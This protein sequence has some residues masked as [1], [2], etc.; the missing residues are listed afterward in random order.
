MQ[1]EML[2]KSA[3]IV[4][5]IGAGV[6]M[7][8]SAAAL[9]DPALA[10]TGSADSPGVDLYAQAYAA[11]AIP[12]GAALLS[13]LTSRRKRGLLPLL[14]VSGAV[15][16]GDVAIGATQGIPGMMVGGTALALIHLATACQLA[17]GRSRDAAV[18]A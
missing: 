16:L 7:A 3:I 10:I 17:I 9:V 4:N 18:I 8:F 12:L 15:Q 1:T 13:S 2:S 6:A 14:T 5:A 11:R